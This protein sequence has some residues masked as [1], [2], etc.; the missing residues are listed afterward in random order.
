LTNHSFLLGSGRISRREFA[1][2]FGNLAILKPE[3]RQ[4]PY[5]IQILGS[6]QYFSYQQFEEKESQEDLSV[7]E[8]AFGRVESRLE[9]RVYLDPSVRDEYGVPMIQVNFSYSDRD[10]EVINQM[11]QGII[12]SASAMGVILDSA[13]TLFSPGSDLHESCTCRMGNDPSTSATNHYGQIHDVPGLYVADNSVLPS[14]AA[15]N[16]TLTT[17]A[18]AFRMADYIVRQSI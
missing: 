1:D 3:T 2:N 15:A 7:A 11:A 5:Q 8:A 17:V 6:G 12:Q 4:S 16:P 10:K 14:L 9:N 13:P 18:L